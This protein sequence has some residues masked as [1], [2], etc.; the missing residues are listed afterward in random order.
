MNISSIK[1]GID[2]RNAL[3]RLE[4]I[5]IRMEEM[6]LKQIEQ[7]IESFTHEVDN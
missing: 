1:N 2:Y 3:T 7:A 4:A 6:Q 5:K